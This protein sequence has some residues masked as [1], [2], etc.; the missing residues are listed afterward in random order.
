[1][2]S[3]A[4]GNRGEELAKQFLIK[5]GFRIL[6]TNYRNRIGEI[7]IIARKGDRIHFV[8][9]KYRSNETFGTGR[10]SVTPRKQKRIHKLATLYLLERKL[11][12][13]IDMS[14]DVI[15]INNNTTEHLEGCF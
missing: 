8:E 1:M 10:E 14:F 11:Y 12:Y 9:V 2:H 15:E 13:N 5:N 7:D 6:Q 4:I 3:K